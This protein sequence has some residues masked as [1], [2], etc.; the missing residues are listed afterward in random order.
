VRIRASLA[1]LLALGACSEPPIDALRLAD[2]WLAQHL[3]EPDALASATIAGV[4]RLAIPIPVGAEERVRVAVP[5]GAVLEASLG[6]GVRADGAAAPASAV[7]EVAACADAGAS[8]GERR[9]LLGEAT[10][11]ATSWTPL[12]IGLE[13]LAGEALTLCLSARPAG[14]SAP[15]VSDAAVV[16]LANATL[17][18][19]NARRWPL[20]QPNLLL[21]TLDTTRGDHL[22]S[23]GYPRATTPNLDRL[24]AE[25]EQYLNAVTNAPFTLP[26]HASLFTGLHPREHGAQSDPAGEHHDWLANRFRALGAEQVT[27]AEQ[28]WALGYRTGAVVAGPMVSAEFGFA[29]GFDAYDQPGDPEGSPDHFGVRSGEEVTD[30]ALAWL[31]ADERPFFLFLNYFDAHWPY[32][33]PPELASKWTRPDAPRLTREEHARI[34]HEVLGDQ[35]DLREAERSAM[36]DAYDAEILAMDRAIGRLLDALRARGDYTETLI[37]VVSDHGEAF[38]EHRLLDHGGSLYEDQLHGALI[39]KYPQGPG[40][41]RAGQRFEQRVDLL[42]LYATLLRELGLLSGS[43][44][45]GKQRGLKSRFDSYGLHAARPYHFAEVRRNPWFVAAYGPR[46][47]RDFEAVYH[48]HWK[49]IRD[50]RG[51]ARLFDLASDPREEHDLAGREPARA[52]QLAAALEGWK[53]ATSPAPEDRGPATLSPDL[54][55]RLRALGYLG[56]P[57]N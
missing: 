43:E 19:P 55:E 49:L 30:R 51:E 24:A 8:S 3:R 50:D 29:Q 23:A 42:D 36:L 46:F 38:G 22:S 40:Q 5:R 31:G 52:K 15:G 37:A 16:W 26:S 7:L 54:L 14:G 45:G 9:S 13:S 47:D 25:G 34:W 21:I 39:V 35:R 10:V 53:R 27:L 33:P 11:E 12:R 17:G 41:P 6:L 56:E 20:G 44:H 2:A 18:P 32:E 48:E 1:L 57:E 4:T 28:L